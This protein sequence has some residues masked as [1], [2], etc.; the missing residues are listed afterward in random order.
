MKYYLFGLLF[1][2]Y[3]S[4]YS[5][6]QSILDTCYSGGGARMFYQTIGENL[7]Y[8]DRSKVG[9]S[10]LYWEINKG[11]I[12]NIT[13][14]NSLGKLTDKHIIRVLQLTSDNWVVKE[15]IDKYYLPIK[16]QTHYD[17]YIDPIP[18]NYLKEIVV[19]AYAVV[20]GNRFQSTNVKTDEEIISNLNKS[21]EKDKF[22]LAI[23]YL[24][25]MIQRNP[26]NQQ[27]REMRILCYQQLNLDEKACNEI[28]FLTNY[29]HA[30]SKYSCKKDL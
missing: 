6:E 28:A 22:K 29:L 17:F 11:Q 27:L 14:I 8:A 23:S 25:Q 9:L 7:K 13:I 19:N 5:Q 18:C 12:Q 15:S 1:S 3:F 21:I 4:T 20:N 2:I 26:L 16:F 10:I 24:D 30:T